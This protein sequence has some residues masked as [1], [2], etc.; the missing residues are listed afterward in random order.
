MIVS[1]GFGNSERVAKRIKR[2]FKLEQSAIKSEYF[3]DKRAQ[4]Q[5]GEPVQAG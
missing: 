4:R 3:V 2:L 1:P 5:V